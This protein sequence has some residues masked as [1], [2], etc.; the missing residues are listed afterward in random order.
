MLLDK[1]DSFRFEQ[2]P[3]QVRVAERPSP[4]E[5]TLAIDDPVAGQVE[6]RRRV[7]HQPSDAPGIPGNPGRSR[8]ITVGSDLAERYRGHQRKDPGLRIVR[9]EPLSTRVDS[10]LSALQ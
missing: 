8:D 4:A 10:L 7:V 6:F 2:R 3:H 1:R 5:P 9:V